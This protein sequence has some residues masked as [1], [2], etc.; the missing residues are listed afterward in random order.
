MR[1]E[2]HQYLKN[3]RGIKHKRYNGSHSRVGN[4]KPNVSTL[5]N[6]TDAIDGNM[7]AQYEMF[8]MNK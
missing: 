2:K 4:P 7:E 8:T 6:R 5:I 1:D 3:L